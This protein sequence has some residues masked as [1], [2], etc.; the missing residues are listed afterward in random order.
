[1]GTDEPHQAADIDLDSRCLA[2]IEADQIAG[3]Q[4]QARRI[5]YAPSLSTQIVCDE[6]KP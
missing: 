4:R 2:S 6:A 5:E 3:A 1:M